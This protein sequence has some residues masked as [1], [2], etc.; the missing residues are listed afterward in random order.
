MASNCKSGKLLQS[1]KQ[2]FW[3]S[4]G[5]QYGLDHFGIYQFIGIPDPV[6][7]HLVSVRNEMGIAPFRKK[8]ALR[9]KGNS[10]NLYLEKFKPQMSIMYLLYF[11]WSDYNT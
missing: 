6:V 8:L 9:W 4:A 1:V 5:S 11:P 7:R 2:I 3:Y 10:D